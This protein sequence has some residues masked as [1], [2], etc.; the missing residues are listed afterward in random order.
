MIPGITDQSRLPRIGK[1][2]LGE[3]ASTAGGKEYPKALPYFSFR[4]VPQVSEVYG[5][6]CVRLSTVLFPSDDEDVFFPTARACYGRSGLFC[7]CRDGKTASRVFVGEK[8]SQGVEYAREHR[9]ELGEGELYELPCLADSCPWTKRDLC[10][11]LG[12][13][14]FMLPKVPGFGVFEI[15]MPS[16]ITSKV[17][18]RTARG[19]KSPFGTF[20]EFIKFKLYT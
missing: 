20:Y 14:L 16:S 6:A 3:K 19:G 2:R 5:A 9:L 15:A 13:L 17:Q 1:I 4:D 11:P 7:K 10:K 8:D 18:Q 12:R